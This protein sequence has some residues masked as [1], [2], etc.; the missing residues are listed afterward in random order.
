MRNLQHPAHDVPHTRIINPKAGVR[1]EQIG[2]RALKLTLVSGRQASGTNKSGSG[3]HVSQPPLDP[4]NSA[5][6]LATWTS[7]SLARR[8]PASVRNFN[9]M[10]QTLPSLAYK[11]RTLCILRSKQFKRLV[12]PR[13][14]LTQI[15]SFQV[16]DDRRIPIKLVTY[17]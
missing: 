12:G 6:C 2:V 16:H 15:H 13:D 5:T 7:A 8:T 17:T 1:T 3:L 14:V 4:T 11:H 10:G 9:A